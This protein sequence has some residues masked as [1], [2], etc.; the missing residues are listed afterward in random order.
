MSGFGTPA[1]E[2][3]TR[4]VRKSAAIPDRDLARQREVVNAFLAA[5][6]VGDCDALL[7]VLDYDVVLRADRE[8]APAMVYFEYAA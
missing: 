5:V 3:R 4:R 2:P 7:A 1:C 8:A 6:R